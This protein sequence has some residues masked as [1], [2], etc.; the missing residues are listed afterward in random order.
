MAQDSLDN[1]DIS[2]FET[3]PKI[4]VESLPKRNAQD[5][6]KYVEERYLQPKPIFPQSWLPKCQSIWTRNRDLN[7][8]FFAEPTGAKTRVAFKRD[9]ISHEICGYEEIEISNQLSSRNSMSMYRSVGDPSSYVRG[10]ATNIP[11][12]PGGLNASSMADRSG[13]IAEDGDM[14]S[15]NID[16]DDES[17]YFTIP[18]G[19][20]R[21]LIF[22]DNGD[23]VQTK[24]SLLLQDQVHLATKDEEEDI[25]LNIVDNIDDIMARNDGVE[26]TT[27][28]PEISV[29]DPDGISLD[30][31]DPIEMTLSSEKPDDG[32]KEWAHMVDITKGF[33]N[34]HELVPNMAMKYKFELDTFQKE[35]VYRLER[36]DSVFVAAHTSAGKTV[37]A[38]YAIALS[39]LHM[40]KTIYTSPIKALSNQKFRDFRNTYGNDQVG[41]LT[42][43]I[44]IRT[45][46]PC[47]VMTT[48]ILR[49]MLY[50]GADLLRDVEFVVFDEVHYVNDFE[51]GMVW[52]EVIIM[53]P[54][55]VS[56]I[57]LSATVPNT[58]EFAEWVG[59]TKKRDIYVIST[60]KR[61]VPLEHFLYVPNQAN[62][63]EEKM[64]KVVDS[65]GKLDTIAWKKAYDTA[66]KRDEFTAKDKDKDKNQ[67]GGKQGR[68]GRGQGRGRGAQVSSTRQNASRRGV[69]Y[70]THA[71]G[72]LK[73]QDLLPAVIFS[74]SRKKCEE[75][76]TTLSNIDFLNSSLKA[77]IH[78]F[79]EDSLKRLKPEDRTLPQIIKMKELLKRGIGIHHSGLLPIIKEI[80]EILF[81]RGLIK[82][83]FAT[84]T[85]AMG[86][87]MPA[88]CVVFSSLRKHDGRDFREL[89]PGEY[90]QMSGRAG[91]RGIDSTGVV[92]IACDKDSVPST[93]TLHNTILGVPTKLDSQFRLTYTMVLNLLRV[94]QLRVEEMIKRSFLE[95]SNQQQ[96]PEQMSLMSKAKHALDSVEKVHCGI[97]DHD[98][99]KLYQSCKRI[100]DI[101]TEIYDKASTVVR[102]AASAN[103]QLN[104][105][106][107]FGRGRVVILNDYENGPRLAILNL[108]GTHASASSIAM[109]ST[110]SKRLQC[111]VLGNTSQS[112][113]H[114]KG[115]NGKAIRGDGDDSDN[116]P[117]PFPL[118]DPVKFARQALKGL[119]NSQ[120]TKESIPLSSV[121]YLMNHSINI[122]F[123]SSIR[124]NPRKEDFVE[125]KTKFANVLLNIIKKNIIEYSWKKIRLLDFQKLI[126]ERKALMESVSSFK[127]MSC[128]QI[129]VHYSI[130][131][132]SQSLEAQ[133]DQLQE[134]LSDS[135]LLLL[136]DYKIRVD[137]LRQLSYIGDD[138]TV[139]LKG[140]VACEVNSAD[141][142]VL[143]ELV[144]N[145]VLAKYEPE[146]IAALLSCFV[147]Q[148]KASEKTEE[149]KT[150]PESLIA[151]KKEFIETA[152]HIAQVQHACGLD[153][154][155][156]DYVKDIMKFGLMEVVYEWGR[157]MP[158]KSITDL[159]DAQEGMIVRCITR[160]DE[161]IREVRTAAKLIGDAALA[162]KMDDAMALIKRDIIF[163]ASLYF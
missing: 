57:M 39:Q 95:H 80:V 77:S 24:Y 109:Q 70:W 113:N 56:I 68:G 158:F 161:V 156:E 22:D 41:I 15:L 122:N 55:H 61:P 86:V 29:A 42:G 51:R 105:S 140:Q 79:I 7:E 139:Q 157:G 111:L 71:I 96:I 144:L 74:F 46:A 108:P 151:G 135:N 143:T 17:S 141:A 81:G 152:I 160:L 31:Q 14:E 91:R 53:L 103:V 127:C 155:P 34:F 137:V 84:E 3:L 119:T 54:P 101:N 123:G 40:T 133:L 36:G 106:H 145:N 115:G 73:K 16:F 132:T 99:L 124:I 43:D 48:E 134:S 159:T 45:E 154:V 59:R 116:L 162:E 110:T 18:D 4:D 9:P 49:S 82:V 44:Q 88:R 2:S 150:L 89:L 163:A 37:V 92:I 35:A 52:E 128:P 6:R 90:T 25:Y 130:T 98:L 63:R 125:L 58:K 69:N 26:E 142:L 149:K 19:F 102:G 114:G 23:T 5:V 13:G 118:A 75:F 8:A 76:A 85:F 60:L 107:L 131:H 50:R 148:E 67:R 21:G 12:V 93:S 87:N 112:K 100:Q 121:A 78:T 66:N 147:C 117:P 153:I 27:P 104:L 83:L 146:E 65:V 72:Y 20:E 47:L 129:K 30:D 32:N 120:I 136:P 138:N 38:E 10:K 1:I 11:F 64:F 62:P 33:P 97:C 94:K 126:A 28:E